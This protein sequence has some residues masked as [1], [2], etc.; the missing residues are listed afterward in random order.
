MRS[1]PRIRLCMTPAPRLKL[2]P[3]ASQQRE[4]VMRCCVRRPILSGFVRASDVILA[5]D[6]L[7]KMKTDDF[8][9][10][11][12]ILAGVYSIACLRAHHLS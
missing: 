3:H 12:L 5:L 10:Y 4:V 6:V 8:Q 11:D 1:F 7:L 9:R 2:I